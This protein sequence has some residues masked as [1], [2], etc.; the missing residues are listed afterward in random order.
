MKIID[1]INAIEKYHPAMPADYNGCDGVKS[2][3]P[4][5]EC[6]GIVCTLVPTFEIVKKTAELGCNLL[7]V[8]EVSYYMTPDFPTWRGDFENEVYE[9]KRRFLEEHGIVI[10]RDHDRTH[11]HK[12]D[13]I[14]YGVIKHLGWERF[15]L[16]DDHS[17]PF[18][19]HFHI[20]TTTVESL[21]QHLIDTIGLNGL[22]YIGNPTDKISRVAIVGHL[23]PNGF[24]VTKEEN[25]Y[26]YDYST[27]I[28]RELESGKVQAIIP[29]E[30]IEWNVLSYIRDAVQMGKPM[31][32]F[33]IGHFSFEE[34]GAKYAASWIDDL[35]DHQVPIQY[36][37][38]GDIWNFQL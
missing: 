2:G 15:W 7:Y 23:Y 27:D 19:F 14:F 17:I 12:P 25:G 13:G 8:H 10:Y 22:R 31:A 20:P 36:V 9:E 32:C 1:I 38:T 16:K 21:N 3:D 30:V 6:T 26:Y 11:S 33:N 35:L 5:A 37:P 4:Q 29:G 24:G 34:L 18:A 28:I